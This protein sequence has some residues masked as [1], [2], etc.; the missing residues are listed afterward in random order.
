MGV[1]FGLMSVI[2][3]GKG[4]KREKVPSDAR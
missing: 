1:Y 3:I 2:E 4:V